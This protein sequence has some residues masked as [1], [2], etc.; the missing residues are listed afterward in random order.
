MIVVDTNVLSEPLRKQPDAS[1][2]Q[3]LTRHGSDL[4]VTT[5]TI[6]ELVYGARRLPIGQRRAQLIDGIEGLL[7][8]VGDR[9]LPVDE[10]AARAYGSLRAEREL[11]GRPISVED[12]LIAGI[13]VSRGARLATRNVKDF[14]GLGVDLIVPW[15]TDV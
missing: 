5:V 4:A 15:R 3:W 1:V 12:G 7:R 13:C 2:L 9:V 14:V 11:T 6:S 10:G 8:R